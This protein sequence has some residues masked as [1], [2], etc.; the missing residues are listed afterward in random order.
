MIPGSWN[1]VPEIW[2][3]AKVKGDNFRT[4]PSNL[5]VVHSY[6]IPVCCR[7]HAV[8][9]RTLLDSPSVRTSEARELQTS[10]VGTTPVKLKLS[11][12]DV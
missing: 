7:L 4:K 10:K 2:N 11:Q 5:A 12:T 9:T 6:R 8:A 1:W 3:S